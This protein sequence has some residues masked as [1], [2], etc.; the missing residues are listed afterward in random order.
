MNNDLFTTI[1][2]RLEVD[3]SA[4]TEEIIE[5]AIRRMTLVRGQPCCVLYELSCVYEGQIRTY[6][7]DGIPIVKVYPPTLSIKDDF[8]R[9][10]VQYEML[11]KGKEEQHEEG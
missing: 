3:L 8:V 2:D 11:V 4:K 7:I 6:C 1:L 5:E 9:G 10:I